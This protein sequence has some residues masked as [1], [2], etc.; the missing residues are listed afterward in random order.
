[1]ADPFESENA[2]K[3]RSCYKLPPDSKCAIR[4]VSK[5]ICLDVVSRKGGSSIV[6]TPLQSIDELLDVPHCF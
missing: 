6:Q 4:E 1:M 3:F 2:Q 5:F